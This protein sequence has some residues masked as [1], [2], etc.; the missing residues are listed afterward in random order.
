MNQVP[1]WTSDSNNKTTYESSMKWPTQEYMFQRNPKPVSDRAWAMDYDHCWNARSLIDVNIDAMGNK[2]VS[3]RIYISCRD[4]YT[5]AN[6][7][8]TADYLYDHTGLNWREE[9]K[10]QWLN[11]VAVPAYVLE[12]CM[13]VANHAA[14]L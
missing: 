3:Y 5:Q 11:S 9:S 2:R 8:D 14:T 1:V 4:T 13:N 12:Y 6:Y 10:R 7:K